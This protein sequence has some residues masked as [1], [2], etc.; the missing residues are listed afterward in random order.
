MRNYSALFAIF[1]VIVVM[2]LVDQEAV[3]SPIFLSKL[4]KFF[5]E[6]RYLGDSYPQYYGSGGYY[7]NYQ[8]GN[9]GN[10]YGN[11]NAYNRQPSPD[12]QA[13]GR[14]Y[15]DICRVYGRPGIQTGGPISNTFPFC[16]YS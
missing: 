1:T 16:P 8:S 12:R 14:S 7:G 2:V 13:R 6:L 10:V 3:A 15:S 11:V 9:R 5:P 4:S